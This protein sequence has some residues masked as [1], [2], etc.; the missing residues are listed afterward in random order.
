MSLPSNA[1]GVKLKNLVLGDK[2]G[3][4][5]TAWIENLWVS[6]KAIDMLAAAATASTPTVF[7]SN[8]VAVTSP[9]HISL[10]D[11][12]NLASLV[13][14]K[15]VNFGVSAASGSSRLGV[16]LRLTFYGVAPRC[17]G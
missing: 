4:A 15:P 2:G 11:D 7:F 14:G 1:K 9:P 3:A 17:V 10:N 8:S 6:P 13:V 16:K 12:S 5:A